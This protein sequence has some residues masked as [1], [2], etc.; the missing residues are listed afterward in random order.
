MLII[1]LLNI[2]VSQSKDG[3]KDEVV[4]TYFIHPT[5]QKSDMYEILNKLQQYN[6]NLNNNK[7]MIH[8]IVVVRNMTKNY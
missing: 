8:K 5:S 4:L 3:S 1:K 7:S 2:F 6:Y